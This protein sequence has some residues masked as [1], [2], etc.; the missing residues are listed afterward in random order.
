MS[1]LSICTFNVHGFTTANYQDNTDKLIR[2]LKEKEYDMI[3]FNEAHY[4][5]HHTH[6]SFDDILSV[7][8]ENNKG[9]VYK[10][11]FGNAQGIEG[12]SIITHLPIKNFK[13]KR[14]ACGTGGERSILGIEIDHS[15]IPFF[16]VTH[17]DHI[18][19][20][21]RLKQI[22]Q[23]LQFIKEFTSNSVSDYENNNN[24]Q[25]QQKNFI[26]VGDF[27]AMQKEDY[28]EQFWEELI[29]QRKQWGWELPDIQVTNYLFNE[30]KDLIDC[31]KECNENV[32]LNGEKYSASSRLNTR[33]DYIICN[34][35]CSKYLTNCKVVNHSE[36]ICTISDHLPVEATFQF[37]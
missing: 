15:H 35:D 5:K 4:D 27:N 13:N 19:E 21:T 24:G 1:S 30:E 34:E 26:L 28:T 6:N 12:N 32:K 20:R 2:F 10:Y 8:N 11:I 31:W 29:N 18:N 7:L 17:L 16:F 36:Y 22:K 14:L 9:K 23:A 33:I 25:L 3:C 37:F